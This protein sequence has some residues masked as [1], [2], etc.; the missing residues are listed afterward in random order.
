MTEIQTQ[1]YGWDIPDAPARPMPPQAMDEWRRIASEVRDYAVERK[2]TQADIARLA[3][4]KSSTLHQILKGS[5]TGKYDG[6][7]DALRNWLN[8]DREQ[9]STKQAL[10]TPPEW[11]ETPSAR[12]V[13]NALSFAQSAPAMVMVTLGS[14]MGKTTVARHY[15]ATR[16]NVFRIVAK[17]TVRTPGQVIRQLANTLHIR[18]IS[19]AKCRDE[20]EARLRRD[21]RYTLLIVDEA[22]FLLE[23][24]V[25]EL[26]YFRDEC[27]TGLAFL[28][29]YGVKRFAAKPTEDG[30]GQIQR[31]FGIKVEELRPLPGDIETYVAAWGFEDREIVRLLHTIGRTHGF[32]GQI[33]ETVKHAAILAAA[34][35][36]ETVTANH[37]R[38]A[39]ENRSGGQKL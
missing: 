22:Q 5:Y 15:M 19:M 4:V 37:I 29:N 14:G 26:R 27:D 25:N 17:P 34:D 20:I 21:D 32:L 28:G 39:W 9:R 1:A 33:D 30:Y 18:G 13:M 2:L 11:V 38:R 8:A 16:P 24:S 3:D 31:R 23:D 7:L 36:S 6:T 10:I 35:G 12:A